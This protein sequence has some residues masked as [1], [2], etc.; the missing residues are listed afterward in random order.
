M[1]RCRPCI[2]YV[3]LLIYREDINIFDIGSGPSSLYKESPFEIN[4]ENIFY[5]HFLKTISDIMSNML[6][7]PFEALFSALWF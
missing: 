6:G 7:R 5:N 1:G 4:K 3:S 2:G